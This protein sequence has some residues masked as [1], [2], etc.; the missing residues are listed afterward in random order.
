LI[1]LTQ[2]PSFAQ[3]EFA[4]KQK[5]TRREQFLA[6]RE[7]LIPWPKLLAVSEPFYPKGQ[8]G[9]PPIGLERMLRVY[10]LQPWY[11]L[12]DKAL[13]DALYDSQATRDL[14]PRSSRPRPP[15]RT[16]PSS[17]IRKCT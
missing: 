14:L 2:Q 5:V 17:A 6:R 13:D 11:G 3:V 8:R 7:E 10:F 12:A 9:R 4:A 1:G 16:R 15:P